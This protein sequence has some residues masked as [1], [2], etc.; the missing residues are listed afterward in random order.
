MPLALPPSSSAINIPFSNHPT[1]DYSD[2]SPK[3]PVH[4]PDY[5]MPHLMKFRTSLNADVSPTHQAKDEN[6]DLLLQQQS[7]VPTH[8]VLRAHSISGAYFTPGVDRRESSGEVGREEE[9]KEWRCCWLYRQV[10]GR[11]G[12][13]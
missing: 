1:Q 9:E 3:F 10:F 11:R 13:V 4:S 12:V 7:P 5:D 6:E 2:S 8:R